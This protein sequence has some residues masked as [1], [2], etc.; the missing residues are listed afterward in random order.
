MTLGES[1][2]PN[3]EVGFV[4]DMIKDSVYFRN[5]CT[6]FTTLLGKKSSLLT[7][8]KELMQRGFRLGSIRKTEFVQGKTTR[9]GLAWTFRK[10]SHT[11]PGKLYLQKLIE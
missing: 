7:L 11:S 3:G 2:Y 5:C 6:W 1:V 8:E 4:L 9:W 10:V